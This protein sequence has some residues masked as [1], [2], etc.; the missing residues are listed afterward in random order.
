MFIA[1]TN[2]LLSDCWKRKGTVSNVMTLRDGQSC[3]LFLKGA[4]DFSFLWKFQTA[5][6]AD[7]AS[8][9][10]GTGSKT[11]GAWRL[12]PTSIYCRGYEQFADILRRHDVNSNNFAFIFIWG[13]CFI[14]RFVWGISQ[15]VSFVGSQLIKNSC[16]VRYW[17][18]SSWQMDS[19]D[20]WPHW[21]TRLTDSNDAGLD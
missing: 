16:P 7:P 20:D 18:Y 14:V 3:C 2:P 11:A 12:T 8:Y 17:G 10:V 4:T 6:Q 5:S 15:F 13:L 19:L 1:L 21:M 9:S